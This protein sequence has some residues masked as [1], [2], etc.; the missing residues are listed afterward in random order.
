MAKKQKKE[1]TYSGGVQPPVDIVGQ[2]MER[3]YN[4]INNE[5][6]EKLSDINYIPSHIQ[7]VVSPFVR[8]VARKMDDLTDLREGYDK[9]SPEHEQIRLEMEKLAG[10]LPTLKDQLG[11]LN[12]GTLDLKKALGSISPGSQDANL[13][14]NFL[15]LAGQADGYH[16]DDD[17]KISMASVYGKKPE[18]ISYF[19]LDDASNPTSGQSPIVIEPYESKANIWR[20]AE[21]TKQNQIE[22]K[23]FD[24]EWVYKRL[25]NELTDKGASNTIG[26]AFADLAGDNSSKSFADQWNDGLADPY[27]YTN[28]ETGEPLQGDS[29]WMKDPANYAILQKYLGKY[30]TN[31]MKDVY[32]VIDKETGQVKK[33]QAQIAQEIVKKYSK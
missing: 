17:G 19:K 28:P 3:G 29:S 18:D 26:L 10:S 2:K 9:N 7:K 5:S 25:M 30:I 31:V 13:Y 27:F 23:P 1:K 16:I 22:G 4:Y 21:E 12:L 6:P 15:V 8:E 20:L 32:G 33:T 11:K 14:T 24:E